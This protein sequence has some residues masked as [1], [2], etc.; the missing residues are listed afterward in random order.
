MPCVRISDKN[1]FLQVQDPEEAQLE[2]AH[3]NFRPCMVT[4]NSLAYKNA[5]VHNLC[6]EK[7]A[8]PN[9]Y[10]TAATLTI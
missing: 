1:R 10:R 7:G 3:P 8:A 9:E 4:T 2:P 6:N 5:C